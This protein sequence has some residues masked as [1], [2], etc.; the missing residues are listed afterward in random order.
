MTPPKIVVYGNAIISKAQ[1]AA[2]SSSHLEVTPIPESY[3]ADR[4]CYLEPF[5]MVLLGATSENEENLERI[6]SLR[7]QFAN[8][9]L[10]LATD[11]PSALYL[12]QAFRYGITDCL[13]TPFNE[14]QLMLLISA[15][16]KPDPARQ[17]D[18]VRFFPEM[19]AHAVPRMTARENIDLNMQFLGTFRLSRHGNRLDLP[20]GIRQRSLLAY[21]LYQHKT[22][23]HRDK[24][25]ENFWPDHDPEFAKNNLNVGICNLRRF[26]D[27]FIKADVICFRNESFY[28]NPDLNFRSDLDEFLQYYHAGRNAECYGND[29]EA[30]SCYRSAT[31]I[32]SEFLEE[33][34]QE[35]WTIR[36]REE[37]TEKFLHALDYLSICQEREKN[38]EAAIDTLR[39]M[40]YKDDCLES[41]HR[42]IMSCY[43]ACGKKVKA[44]RQYLECERI[45]KEKLD[46]RPSAETQAL[47]L[48]AKAE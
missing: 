15:Y 24:I 12:I 44:V 40:L 11:N 2:L 38:Y 3:P 36:P 10:I 23:V 31:Q 17:A 41:V 22:A 34:Q 35:N 13:L 5:Q 4:L 21:L 7:R 6:R 28:L 48:R 37:F 29:K 45:L 47:Y 42:R 46:M 33:F 20:G 27:K 26:L 18:R 30:A 8:I 25:M 43:L 39:Q 32:G 19:F 9:P 16:L 1:L 14:E